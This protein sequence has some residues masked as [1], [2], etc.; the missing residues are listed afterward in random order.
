MALRKRLNKKGGCEYANVSD[1]YNLL[2]DTIKQIKGGNRKGGREYAS[3]NNN[4]NLLEDA[5]KQIKGGNRKGGC[6]SFAD[7]NSS[8]MISETKTGGCGCSNTQRMRKGGD[9]ISMGQ[10]LFNQLQNTTNQQPSIVPQEKVDVASVVTDEKKGGYRRSTSQRIHKGGAIEL[11]PF[12]AAVALMAARYMT[13][14]DIHE[15]I[16]SGKSSSKKPVK[17]SSKKPVKSSSKKPVKKTT[18]SY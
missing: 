16:N 2:E 4:Y 9:L 8:Y 17:S 3:V 5:I 14:I 10:N 15:P 12:A 18:K 6:S 13:D 1:N 11:A 7:V